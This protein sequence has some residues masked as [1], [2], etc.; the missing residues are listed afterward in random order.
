MSWSR[1]FTA[2][3][4]SISVA[5][6]GFEPLY[7]N[8]ASG[9]SVRSALH[10]IRVDPIAD[11]VG[12]VLRNHLQ[13][14]LNPTGQISEPQWG[15]SVSLKESVSEIALEAANY[16]TRANLSLH[17]EIVFSPLE[18]TAA[19]VRKATFRA[20]SSYNLVDSEYANLVAERDARK[21]A[22]IDLVEDIRRQLVLW[23]RSETG[24]G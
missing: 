18:G 3:F 13:T 8:P 1:I 21:R 9:L 16:S 23:L 11:R 24:T 2:V 10:E 15:L 12:Q 17:A 20:V 5:G 19:K 14:A 22:A 6:C 4:L 7:R